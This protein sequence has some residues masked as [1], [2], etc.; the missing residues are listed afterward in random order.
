MK[1]T[2]S[3]KQNEGN[4]FLKTL[5][6]RRTRRGGRRG[7]LAGW[8][9]SI[10]MINRG[11]DRSLHCNGNREAKHHEKRKKNRARNIEASK[12][13]P[14]CLRWQYGHATAAGRVGNEYSCGHLQ[15]PASKNQFLN[16]LR[17]ERKRVRFVFLRCCRSR[18]STASK[19]IIVCRLNWIRCWEGV[20]FYFGLRLFLW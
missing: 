13:Q 4:S 20:C 9:L 8:T 7:S 5:K 15:M 10:P 1:W 18:R 12:Q 16:C 17:L 19:N 2:R 11:G 6:K 14:S 3:R